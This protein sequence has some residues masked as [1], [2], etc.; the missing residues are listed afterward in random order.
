VREGLGEGE[1]GGDFGGGGRR[2]PHGRAA[3]AP[4]ARG[5]RGTRGGARRLGRGAVG[6]AAAGP[7]SRPRAGEGGAE[8]GRRGVAG[9]PS[10]L[11][12]AGGRRLGR[13]EAGPKRGGIPFYFSF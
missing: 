3:A 2:V 11:G 5:E 1:G 10:R 4:T 12:H 7:P 8:L 9:P 6:Q 13:E